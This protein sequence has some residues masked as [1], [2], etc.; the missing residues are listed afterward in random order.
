MLEL[1][2][3]LQFFTVIE[4][5]RAWQGQVGVSM[6]KISIRYDC[7]TYFSL[8]FDWKIEYIELKGRN[9]DWEM[10]HRFTGDL[11]I[12]QLTHFDFVADSQ[13]GQRISVCG[14]F[15]IYPLE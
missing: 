4:R 3:N 6:A 15:L 11:K 2:S 8:F 14:Q 5:S 10:A 13:T 12:D 9:I 7:F 1:C